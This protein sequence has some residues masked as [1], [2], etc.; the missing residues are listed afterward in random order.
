MTRQVPRKRTNVQVAHIQSAG[1]RPP[2]PDDLTLKQRARWDRIVHAALHLLEH[3]EYEQIQIREV[4]DAA[5]VALGT[6]YRY[7]A[8]K[9]HLFAAVLVEWSDSLQNG[10]RRRPLSGDD[11]PTQLGELV[12]RALAAFERLPQFFRLIVLIETTSD[13]YVRELYLQFMAH[14]Q[15]TF[16][17]PLEPLSVTDR[18]AVMMLMLDS[19]GATLRAV[20]LDLLTPAEARARLRRTIELIF[21]PPPK[22][23]RRPTTRS[24]VLPGAGATKKPHSR[25]RTAASSAPPKRRPARAVRA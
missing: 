16:T 21:S 22:V 7:F 10:V 20:A 9:E 12:D 2:N 23:T 11:V 1:E 19:L 4:A 8:S 18:D 3:N 24:T 17:E 6:V 13:P 14:T 15:S 5:Q 25:K